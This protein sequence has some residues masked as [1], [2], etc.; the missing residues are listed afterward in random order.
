MAKDYDVIVIG[1]G[2]GGLVAAATTAAN[3]L[4]TLLIEK[5]NIPG[6]CAT[7]FVRGRFEFEPSLHELCDLGDPATGYSGEVNKIFEELKVDVDWRY[8]DVSFRVV[9]PGEK[10]VDAVLPAGNV[11]EFIDAMEREVPGCRESVTKVFELAKLANEAT[12]YLLATGGKP[13]PIKMLTKYGDFMRM[14]SHSVTECLDALDMPKKAQLILDT[15][16][17]YL[18]TPPHILD[19]FHYTVM[20][21]GYVM[22]K[23]AMP[24]KRSHEI[25]LALEKRI[26]DC[27][28]DIW[29][30][31]EATKILIKDNKAYGVVIGGREI[32]AKQIISNA[33]PHTVFSKMVDAKDVPKRE[34]KLNNAR[35]IGA[36]AFTMYLGL[37]RSKEELGIKDYTIFLTVNPD[38]DARLRVPHAVDDDGFFVVNCLN[39]VIPDSSPEGTCT[40]FFTYLIYGDVW[41]QIKPED[42]KKVKRQIADKMIDEYEQGT[43]VKIR[44]Y[45]EEIETAAPPT[46]ARYLNTPRGSIYGYQITEWDSL[47][48]RMMNMEEDWTVENLRFCGGHSFRADGYSSAY[49]TGDTVGKIVVG[50]IKAEKEGK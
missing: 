44:P 21:Y 25:S 17:P 8:D 35:E 12:E 39:E 48:S 24:Y 4:R 49:A 7:S 36:S 31:T 2:N 23:P 41:E 6:G 43:G 3:G 18:G 46:F 45:I 19:M 26:R 14:A 33:T 37:N 1:A 9:I 32:Y 15:Y 47:M 16:W 30:N 10:G 20:L 5:H 29:Y 22:G 28:G 13:N 11:Q 42:Y 50:A 34:L 38:P 27:G 40:L